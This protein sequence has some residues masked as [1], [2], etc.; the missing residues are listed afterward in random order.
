MYW[1]DGSDSGGA[2]PWTEGHNTIGLTAPG[3]RWL[4]AEGRVGGPL[5]NQTYILL[6]NPSTTTA[7]E[8]TITYLRTDGTVVQKPYVVPP[9]SRVNVFVNGVVPELQ[10]ES[11]GASI[12][13]GNGAPIFVERS[14]YWTADGTVWAGGTNATATRMP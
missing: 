13:V 10:D 1:G 3:L 11:F 7:A 8:V 14:L 4:L 6:G 2:F 12:A 9:T 5:A